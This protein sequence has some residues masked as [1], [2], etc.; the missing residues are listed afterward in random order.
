MHDAEAKRRKF[1]LQ[2]Q[3]SQAFKLKQILLKEHGGSYDK[4]LSFLV[5]K[6]AATENQEVALIVNFLLEVTEILTSV[7]V[8]PSSTRKAAKMSSATKAEQQQERICKGIYC[9]IKNV[10]RIARNS[11]PKPTFDA[12]TT[13]LPLLHSFPKGNNKTSTILE[14]KL[15]RSSSPDNRKKQ[16]T[17]EQGK[18]AWQDKILHSI[19]DA[20]NQN[21]G[22]P[23]DAEKVLS[24]VYE[25]AKSAKELPSFIEARRSLCLN[26][27]FAT[28]HKD[29]VAKPVSHNLQ[30]C[31]QLRNSFYLRCKK[32]G[33]GKHWYHDCPK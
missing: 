27:A 13:L 6:K 23:Y 18:K 12:Y 28:A 2:V 4:F 15:E 16:K 22:R 31:K 20:V 19:T 5:K 25:S 11:A 29:K 10:R 9:L 1:K 26:C 17:N 30:K 14:R 33:E 21:P 24:D 3:K 32:C 8:G 7:N